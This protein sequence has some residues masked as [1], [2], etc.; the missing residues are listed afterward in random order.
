MPIYGLS[1]NA[2]CKDG[3][4]NNAL[5]FMGEISNRD[6]FFSKFVLSPTKLL[7]VSSSRFRTKRFAT[8]QKRQQCSY[9]KG[10]DNVI[11]AKKCF[12]VFLYSQI[13]C[14]KF[15]KHRGHAKSHIWIVSEFLTRKMC[16]KERKWKMTAAIEQFCFPYEKWRLE[17]KILHC[18]NLF[19]MST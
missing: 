18:E 3:L 9:P 2:M 6:P 1:R 17:V 8:V 13:K 16:L 5:H 11:L 12:F 19:N 14:F 10:R 4:S 7:K 15:E